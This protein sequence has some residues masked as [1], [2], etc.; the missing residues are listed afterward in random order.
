M[1]FKGFMLK[2]FSPLANRWWVSWSNVRWRKHTEDIE[3]EPDDEIGSIDSIY[4]IAQVAKNMYFDFEWTKDGIDEL[5][6]SICPPPYNYR[7][8]K[9]G[10]LE[11]DCDGFSS[12]M[13]HC[14]AK[15]GIKCY[16]MAVAAVGGAHCVLLFY[17]NGLWGIVDYDDVYYGFETAKE[18]I[19][20]YNTEFIE[21][22]VDDQSQKVQSNFFVVYDYNKKKFKTAK[23]KEI[24]K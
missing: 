9:K 21:M 4:D 23:V 18:A 3:L 10:I 14:L 11:D 2:V 17:V 12:L 1:S 19:K 7:R 22:Y 20:T 13:Y 15:S 16:L 8:I 6:D 24:K 5:K